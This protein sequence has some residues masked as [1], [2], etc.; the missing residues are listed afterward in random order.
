VEMA[1]FSGHGLN[2]ALST[3][4]FL[5]LGWWVDGKLGS[6]PLFTVLG[7]LVGAAAGFYSLL[8][9]LLFRPRD[10]DAE[11]VPDPPSEAGRDS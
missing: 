6:R 5:L 11:E 9:H 10:R 8:Q 4:L 7:A 1:R 3:A 2:L